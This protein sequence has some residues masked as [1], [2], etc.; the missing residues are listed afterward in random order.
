MRVIL[1]TVI[2]LALV[3]V[4]IADGVSMYGA[5]RNAVNLAAQAAE[6]AAQTYVDTKGNEDAVHRTVQDMAADK[7]VA[8]LDLSYHKGTTRWY[9]VSVEATGS[10]ILLKR[11]PYFKDHIAQRSTAIT[12]F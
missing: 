5:H 8:L 1:S 7:G 10:S 3:A 2:L 4:F 9:E 6:Q 11:L 12:H